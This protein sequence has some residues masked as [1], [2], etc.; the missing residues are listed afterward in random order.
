MNFVIDATVAIKWFVAEEDSK[1]A[2]KLRPFHYDCH[3]PQSLIAEVTNAAWKK[4]ARGEIE[5]RQ[6]TQIAHHLPS[7]VQN[8]HEVATLHR[9]ALEIAISL[10]HPVYDCLYLACAERVDGAMITADRRLL[11][12]V[13][14]TPFASRLHHLAALPGE[15]LP[16]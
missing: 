10:Q 15:L 1:A 4:V 3:A 12:A 5:A 13:K 7:F 16:I 2:S 11:E 8:L 9:R 14:T 6:A